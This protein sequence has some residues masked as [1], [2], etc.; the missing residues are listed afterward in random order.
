MVSR[1]TYTLQYLNGLCILALV[2]L[3]EQ[4][5]LVKS[6]EESRF[7]HDLLSQPQNDC[8]FQFKGPLIDGIYLA[9]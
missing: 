8:S 1:G 5:I 4:C 2:Y 7:I 6:E 9:Q 3:S